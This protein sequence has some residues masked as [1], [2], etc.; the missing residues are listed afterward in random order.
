MNNL[1]STPNNEHKA[2]VNLGPKYLTA[3]GEC[4]DT[5][6]LQLHSNDLGISEFHSSLLLSLF[7]FFHR[8][9]QKYKTGIV[10]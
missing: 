7:F 9:F 2:P 5:D 3:L 10:N 4:Y 8:L 6:H 1:N